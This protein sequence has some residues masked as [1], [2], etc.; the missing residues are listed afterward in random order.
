METAH[1][2]QAFAYGESMMRTVSNEASGEVYFVAKDVAAMLGYSNTND[3]IGVH[4]K[5]SITAE[6]FLKGVANRY[7]LDREAGFEGGVKSPPPLPK[8]FQ[9]QTK[10]I[11]EGDVWRL[12]IR[13][14]MPEAE[15]IEEWIMEEV[16]PSIRKSGGYGAGSGSIDAMTDI[17]GRAL[18]AVAK[19]SD[20]L[21]TLSDRISALETT[22]SA[23]PMIDVSNWKPRDGVRDNETTRAEFIEAVMRLLGER[24]EGVIQ[25]HIVA[26]IPIHYLGA[27]TKIRWL[28]EFCGSFWRIEL[29]APATYIY[30]L[31]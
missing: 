27:S 8:N 21:A 11:P 5:K 24:P 29:R 10:L 23:A 19:V 4:C 3:A 13:S 25:S 20:A 14:N 9:L 28:R 15:R 6:E 18:E 7:P 26:L 30:K 1:P 2:L 22:K 31:I 16:L 17:A 12:I